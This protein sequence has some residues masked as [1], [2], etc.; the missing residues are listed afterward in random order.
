MSDLHTHECDFY[1]QSVV[2][3]LS[4]IFTQIERFP[5]VKYDTQEC[6][7]NKL[8]CG[9]DTYE[10]DYDTNECDFDTLESVLGSH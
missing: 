4:V 6:N 9:F 2:S 10:S 3:S 8:E 1:T 5:H 7:L